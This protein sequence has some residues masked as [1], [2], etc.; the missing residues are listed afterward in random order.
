MWWDGY[1]MILGPLFMI[2]MLAVVIAIVFLLV[3][4]LG[5][6]WQGTPPHQA[7]PA[8]TAVNILNER[9]ARGEIDKDE[10]EEK[11]KPPGDI[12]SS[13]RWPASFGPG[14]WPR[15]S[16]VTSSLYARARHR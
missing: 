14:S 11:Q 15:V 8:Q 1:G 9:F 3:R 5:A 10:Y 12:R 2:L 7:P 6:P 13:D 16:M 4:W